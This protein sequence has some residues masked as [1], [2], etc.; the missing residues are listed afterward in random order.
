[1]HPLSAEFL[2][3]FSSSVAV[4][5]GNGLF[6]SVSGSSACTVCSEGQIPQNPFLDPSRG[7]VRLESRVFENQNHIAV[8]VMRGRVGNSS[9]KGLYI[10]SFFNDAVDGLHKLSL[11]VRGGL[12]ERGRQK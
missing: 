12:V 6:R 8:C 11:S 9:R 7:P 4:F 1:M 2:V 3:R 10:G 5:L